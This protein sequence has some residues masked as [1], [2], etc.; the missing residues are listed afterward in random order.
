MYAS[1]YKIYSKLVKEKK[2]K[3]D[4]KSYQNLPDLI[5]LNLGSLIRLKYLFRLN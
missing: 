3:I 5:V 4:T 1:C 2:L